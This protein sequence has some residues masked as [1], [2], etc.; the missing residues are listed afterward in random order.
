MSTYHCASHFPDLSSFNLRISS[1]FSDEETDLAGFSFHWH[2]TTV[3]TS[4][5]CNQ[6]AYV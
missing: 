5:V 6:T 2:Y 3:D 4:T 1:N